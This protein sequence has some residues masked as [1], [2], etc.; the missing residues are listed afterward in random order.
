MTPGSYV[1]GLPFPN[2]ES[3][4]LEKHFAAPT[5]TVTVAFSISYATM[6]PGTAE[7]DL[8]HLKWDQLPA[9]CTSFGYYLVRDG[10]T[11]VFDLQETYGGCGGNENMGFSA[12]QNTGFHQVKMIVTL[13]NPGHVK[14][15]VDEQVI[16]KNTSHEILSSPLTLRIGGGAIRNMVAP[17]TIQYDDVIVD[18]N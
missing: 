17:W 18:V 1:L 2:L 7:I 15:L 16:D 5:A 12:L 6:M 8:V 14:V 3:G 9:P 11:G 4:F 10:Q 13:G